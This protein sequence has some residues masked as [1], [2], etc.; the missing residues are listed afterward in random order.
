MWNYIYAERLNL[1][2][3]SCRQDTSQS[4]VSETTLIKR[5]NLRINLYMCK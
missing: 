5:Y 1:F 4:I 2:Y 3:C